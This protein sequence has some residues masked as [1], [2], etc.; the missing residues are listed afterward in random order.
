MVHGG[1]KVWKNIYHGLVCLVK[2]F[3]LLLEV[4]QL[5]LIVVILNHHL[6]LFQFKLRKVDYVHYINK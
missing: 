3:V 4:V 5:F 2:F 1:V 6:A